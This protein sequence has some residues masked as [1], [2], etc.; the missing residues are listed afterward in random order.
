MNSIVTVK[1][2]KVEDERSAS[3]AISGEAIDNDVTEQDSEQEEICCRVCDP[4][5]EDIEAEAEEEWEIQWPLRD[6]GMPTRREVLEHN[7]THLPPRPWCPHCLKGKGKD[8]PSLWLKGAFAENLVPRIRLD[9][10]FLT[11]NETGRDETRQGDDDKEELDKI[12][13]PWLCR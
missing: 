13:S 7:L 8:S 4:V 1:D 10:C 3:N 6:P 2:H 5:D 9:Y 11:E 12:S